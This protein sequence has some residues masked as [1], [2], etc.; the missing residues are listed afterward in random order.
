MYTPHSCSIGYV[1]VHS[2][3]WPQNIWQLDKFRDDVARFLAPTLDIAFWSDFL[4]PL[5]SSFGMSGLIIAQIA[6]KQ[7]R[8]EGA[9]A[10]AFGTRRSQVR[11]NFRTR[12]PHDIYIYIYRLA[13]YLSSAWMNCS[14]MLY[15]LCNSRRLFLTSVFVMQS[16][17]KLENWRLQL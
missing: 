6:A 8:S 5:N 12:R 10:T 14:T 15:I 16:T 17:F 1:W 9:G 2:I 4:D 11:V 7:D 3:P 13:S